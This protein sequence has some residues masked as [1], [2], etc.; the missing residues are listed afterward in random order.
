MRILSCAMCRF[1][2]Y[3]LPV[4]LVAFLLVDGS[5]WQA[6]GSFVMLFSFRFLGEAVQVWY[7]EKKR[8]GPLP[9]GRPCVAAH[10]HLPCG[11]LSAD[12]AAGRAAHDVDSLQH[13]RRDR[14]ASHRRGELLLC[15]LGLSGL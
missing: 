6:L 12:S 7:Y 5:V 13:P 10:R 8:N 2:L 4:L 3:F 14:H 1:F 15:Y 11:S 9:Q